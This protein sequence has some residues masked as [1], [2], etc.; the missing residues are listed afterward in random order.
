MLFQKNLTN[1]VSGPILGSVWLLRDMKRRVFYKGILNHCYQRTADR[2]LLFYSYSDHLA[3]F[4]QY[5]IM[6][7]K[8]GIRVLSLCQMPDH[9][10]DS[11]ITER[12]Q[13]LEKFKQD[14][15]SWFAMR[16]NE[17]Y[18]L[19]GQV[20]EQSFGSA[21]KRG[22]KKGSSNLVYVGNNPVERRLVEKA[23]QYRWNYLA[24]AVSDHPFSKKL[25]IRDASW[26]L[27][28]A[29]KVVK[30]Q[31]MAGK[32]LHFNQLERL[33]APLGWD[34]R[35]QLTDFIIT[36]YNCI[37]YTAA[38]GYF[39]SYE[40][41]LIAMHATTGSEYDIREVFV[42][43]SDAPYGQMTAFLLNNQYV[44]DIHQ[45]LSWSVDEKYELFLVLRKVMDAPGEQF[46][47]FLHL[48][49]RKKG[50]P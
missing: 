33:F 43:K 45:I 41:M 20:F 9:V 47:K 37:D 18:G 44:K 48:P 5:C 42:G 2:G 22:N 1:F 49:I 25:V 17:R 30:A 34:E 39:G 11:V 23:E 35:Q 29:V 32:P 50:K 38:L 12:K 36:T 24:Y 31:F 4:T 26:P 8:Y 16:W 6:A 21:P 27:Q 40:N 28:K 13:D 19:H 14:T 3:Y 10:H 7:R 46:F 15:N